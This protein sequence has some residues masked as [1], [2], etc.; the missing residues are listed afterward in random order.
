MI[1]KQIIYPLR[2]WRLHLSEAE[3]EE[4]LFLDGLSKILELPHDCLPLGRARTGIYLL[5]KAHLTSKRTRV[6]LSPYTIPDV[7]N[8]VIF[9]GGIPEFVDHE[10]RSTHIDLNQLN[11]ALNDRVGCVLLTHYHVNQA[12]LMEIQEL[13]NRKGVALIEDCAISLGGTSQGKSVGLQ[14]AGGVFSLSSFKFLNYF[15]G[16]AIVMSDRHL[17]SRLAEEVRSWKRFRTVDYWGQMLRTLKYDLATHP[18]LFDH[19]TG[20]LLRFKQRRS[21]A[22]QTLHQPRI[23][24]VNFDDTLRSRPSAGA[25]AEWNRKLGTVKSNLWHRRGIAAVY[26]GVLGECMVSSDTPAAVRE[27]SCFVNYPVWVGAEARDAIYKEMILA[28]FDVGLSL[29]PNVHEHPKFRAVEG[30]SAEVSR[31][32]DSV[33]YLPTHPRVTSSYADSLARHLRSLL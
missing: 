13:C 12:S 16:G 22:V 18:F 27:A 5:V 25:F 14:S 2:Y 31:L 15:W 20:P 1:P 24:S 23:E 21:N 29:Y 28:E 33:I 17:Q 4:R 7:V 9:A 19:I 11:D 32:C 8:M 3:A 30:R 6:L 10:A 26:D